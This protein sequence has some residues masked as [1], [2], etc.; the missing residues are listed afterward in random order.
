MSF[1]LSLCFLFNK[2][3]RIRGQNS[4]C[5]EAGVGGLCGEWQTIYTQVSKCKM[6]KYF[7]KCSKK[8]PEEWKKFLNIAYDPTIP[9][10][11]IYVKQLKAG[12]Q[13]DVGASMFIAAL[14]TM[15]KRWKKLKYPSINDKGGI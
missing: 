7:F 12:P 14:F 13:I 2:I 11:S 6:I 9:F 15:A 10:L 3:K 8:A 5:P 1:L 4:F